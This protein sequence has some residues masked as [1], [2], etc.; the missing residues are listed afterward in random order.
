[1][2]PPAPRSVFREGGRAKCAPRPP[3]KWY[4]GR[5]R[6][7]RSATARLPARVGR[8]RRVRA[9][10][11]RP[12]A[13]P[14]VQSAAAAALP[15]H[16][17]PSSATALAAARA[18]VFRQEPDRQRPAVQHRAA[19]WRGR[20][21]RRPP[22]AP[23]SGGMSG[24]SSAGGTAA[25]TP[26]GHSHVRNTSMSPEAAS[27]AASSLFTSACARRPDGGTDGHGVLG[28]QGMVG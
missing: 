15:A 27:T 18:P 7:A 12:T 2:G 16:A 25:Q 3:A 9:R 24:G 14:G 13:A 1:M 28:G 5:T 11:A 22:P 21:R 20:G 4:R 10:R 26:A 17:R 8:P 19:A 23:A 6:S